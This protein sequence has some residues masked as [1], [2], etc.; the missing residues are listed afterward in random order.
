[1]ISLHVLRTGISAVSRIITQL[2]DDLTG[3]EIEDGQGVTVTFSID[4]AAYE[5]DL[6]SQGAADMRQTFQYYV[7]HG[8]RVDGRGISGG[9]ATPSRTSSSGTTRDP[10]RTKAIRT[11]ARENGQTISDRGRIPASVVEA[12]EAVH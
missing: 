7:D 10:G 11:W 12:Y 2:V 1:M 6:D 9:T 3:K 4:G 5:I 8:R